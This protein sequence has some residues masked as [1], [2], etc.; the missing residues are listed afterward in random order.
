L[1]HHIRF[2]TPVSAETPQKGRENMKDS[3]VRAGRIQGTSALLPWILIITVSVSPVMAQQA[4]PPESNIRT[5][6]GNQGND[7]SRSFDEIPLVST[8]I[9]SALPPRPV[10]MAFPNRPAQD[11]ADTAHPGKRSPLLGILLIAGGIAAAVLLLRGGDD[12]KAPPPP[13][14]QA[15]A[16]TP[17]GTILSAGPPV[18]N[19]PSNR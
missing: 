15:S 6:S 10:G 3:N 18:V 19:P 8:A 5:P 2:G 9:L 14:A 12:D 16:V 1:R 17:S 13:P 7:R 4:S 11:N